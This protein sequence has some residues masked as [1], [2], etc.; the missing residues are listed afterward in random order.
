MIVSGNTIHMM[1]KAAAPAW[2]RLAGVMAAV[3]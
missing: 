2:L 3:P 1:F